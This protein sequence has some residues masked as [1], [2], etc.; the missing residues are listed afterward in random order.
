LCK[1]YGSTIVRPP[2]RD[3]SHHGCMESGHAGVGTPATRL[4]GQTSTEPRRAQGGRV[5][6]GRFVGI[7]GVDQ[8][9]AAELFAR[10]CERPIG[11]ERFTVAHTDAGCR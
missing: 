11:D 6:A 8:E 7:L 9:L 3:P 10:L 1:E 5:A 4:T 2:A